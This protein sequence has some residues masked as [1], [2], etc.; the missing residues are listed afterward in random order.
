MSTLIY[1]SVADGYYYYFIGIVSTRKKQ[2][3]G[4]EGREMRDAS[5]T[6]GRGKQVEG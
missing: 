5:Q 4:E 2:E 6:D 3:E 1:T